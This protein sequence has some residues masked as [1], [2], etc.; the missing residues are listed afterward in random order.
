MVFFSVLNTT[1]A[2]LVIL[3][4]IVGLR[5]LPSGRRIE[6][7]IM[8]IVVSV[9]FLTLSAASR[10]NPPLYDFAISTSAAGWH[11][12]DTCVLVNILAHQYT[13]TLRRRFHK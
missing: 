7:V 9:V 4:G 2:V 1:L 8:N 12:F 13:Y 10:Q 5:C 11:L 6:P 3:A